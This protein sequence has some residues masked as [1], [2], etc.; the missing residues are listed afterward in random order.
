MQ[1]VQI[2][3]QKTGGSSLGI[4]LRNASQ[5]P[6]SL[7]GI[8]AASTCTLAGVQE[9]CRRHVGSFDFVV[10]HVPYGIA[11]AV[12][13]SAKFITILRDPVDR[14][15]S[16]Y[17]SQPENKALP[18][19]NLGQLGK[20]LPANPHAEWALRNLH[21]RMLADAPR[22]GERCTGAM[23]AEAKR[24]LTRFDIVG[25]YDRYTEM[26]RQCETLFGPLDVPR[27]MVTG[28]YHHLV[29]GKHRKIV[30]SLNKLDI[31]LWN[32]ARDRFL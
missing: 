15:L 19:F 2:H 20:L 10:A 4:A 27:V 14:V 32:W 17:C 12:F 25:F 29:T 18:D 7:V 22:F 11:S 6:L 13:K 30:R 28:P 23:L 5:S 16:D 1:V 3:I 9:A 24:N 21:V 8:T 31:E 26:A